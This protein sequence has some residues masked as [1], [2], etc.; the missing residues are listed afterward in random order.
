MIAVTAKHYGIDTILTFNEDFKQ[1]PWLKVIPR[2]RS[3]LRRV[4]A[5]GC[6]EKVTLSGADG[7]GKTTIARILSA[8]LVSR[9][10]GVCIHWFRGS[11][12]LAS[13]LLRFLASA[14]LIALRARRELKNLQKLKRPS[15]PK[16]QPPST[17]AG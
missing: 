8:Y 5:L 15:Y 12:L 14:Y 7:S 10:V 17:F 6:G 11:Y 2:S 9:G 3:P 13:A 1:I 16:L 4:S